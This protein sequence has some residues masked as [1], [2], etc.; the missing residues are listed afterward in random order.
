MSEKFDNN[1]SDNLSIKN[2]SLGRFEIIYIALKNLYFILLYN[3][4]IDFTLYWIKNLYL[5]IHNFLS[6]SF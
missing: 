3:K 5:F 4:I 1:N 2:I 6:I